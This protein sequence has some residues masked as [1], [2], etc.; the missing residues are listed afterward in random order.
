MPCPLQTHWGDAAY[1]ITQ[2]WFIPTYVVL[3]GVSALICQ[4]LLSLR[5]RPLTLRVA[6]PAHADPFS[7]PAASPPSQIYKLTRAW[8]YLPLLFTPAIISLG[9]A[10]ATASMAATLDL[11]GRESLTKVVILWLAAKGASPP[12]L[13]LA[14]GFLTALS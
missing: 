9:G 7:S 5:V 11:S 14:T 4:G 1:A 10:C 3:C 2:P 6:L 8:W 13:F 12:P